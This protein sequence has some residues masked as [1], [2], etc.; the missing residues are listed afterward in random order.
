MLK[1]LENQTSMTTSRV[2]F[3]TTLL[4][5]M[6]FISDYDHDGY[7]QEF[8]CIDFGLWQNMGI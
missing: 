6:S 7:V 8:Y 3:H 5:F 4:L 1:F 2:I